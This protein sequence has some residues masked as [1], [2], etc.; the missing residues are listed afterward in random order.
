MENITNDEK[1]KTVPFSIYEA[2]LLLD[3]YLESKN[4][5]I[6]RLRVV[7]RLSNDLRT[8]A[9]NEG[10]TIDD[11]FRSVDGLSY[12]ITI[13]KDAFE[14]NWITTLGMRCCLLRLGSACVL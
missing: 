2:V 13:M 3:A 10:K 4:A 14:K 9:I 6:P 12:Q 5:E 1:K 11:S 8:M 7:K